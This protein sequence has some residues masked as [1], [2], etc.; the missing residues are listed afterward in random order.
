MCE[1]LEGAA[2]LSGTPC[3]LVCMAGFDVSMCLI[4]SK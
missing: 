3:P 2:K 1:D 4:P